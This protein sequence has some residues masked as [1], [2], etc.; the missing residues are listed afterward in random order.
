MTAIERLAYRRVVA[1]TA[2][3]FLSYLT[4]AMSLPAVPIHVV[5]GLGLGNAWGGLAVGIAFLSTIRHAP[6]PARGPTA[7]AASCAC[8]AA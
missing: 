6:V 8:S 5:N 1:L 3:L 4:V 7:S 2:A